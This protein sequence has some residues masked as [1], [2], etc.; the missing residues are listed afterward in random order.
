V[1]GALVGCTTLEL[2]QL[3]V[4]GC[5]TMF[6]GV[7][8]CTEVGTLQLLGCTTAVLGALAGCSTV[9]LAQLVDE[10]KRSADPIQFVVGFGPDR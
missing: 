3:V 10:G 8:V 4:A 5:T 7:L 9:G 6:L 2:A 1:L